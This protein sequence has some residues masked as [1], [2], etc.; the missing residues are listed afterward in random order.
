MINTPVDGRDYF[1]QWQM[2][3]IPRGDTVCADIDDCHSDIRTFTGN[4][5]TRWT[6]HITRT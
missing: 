1:E 2:I 6:A 3:R 5:G 4:D